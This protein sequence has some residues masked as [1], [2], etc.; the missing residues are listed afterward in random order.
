M[1]MTWDIYSVPYNYRRLFT[2]S[3]YT[4][5]AGIKHLREI[6]TEHEPKSGL[7]KVKKGK[8]RETEDQLCFCKSLSALLNSSVLGETK[9]YLKSLLE[10][11]GSNGLIRREEKK[12]GKGKARRKTRRAVSMCFHSKKPNHFLSSFRGSVFLYVVILQKGNFYFIT[13]CLQSQQYVKLC[14]FVF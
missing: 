7:I 14:P 5:R 4:I 2:I 13:Q 12:L 8:T 11:M 6:R 9:A 10:N 3:Y 1:A